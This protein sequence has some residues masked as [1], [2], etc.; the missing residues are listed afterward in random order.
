MT[1]WIELT[2]RL[3]SRPPEDG[4]VTL[5]LVPPVKHGSALLRMNLSRV[6]MEALGWKPK[7]QLTIAFSK[8]GA[9]LRIT[10]A[11]K[12]VE[13]Y[14]LGIR[15]T[16]GTL[17]FRL[18]WLVGEREARPSEQ[19]PH[20]THTA[21]GA[22]IVNLPAWALAKTVS[23]TPLLVKNKKDAPPPAPKPASQVAALPPVAPMPPLPPMKPLT[24]AEAEDLLVQEGKDLLRGG[25][26]VRDV[27]LRLNEELGIVQAWKRQV[28]AE[29][30]KAAA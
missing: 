30:E 18:P 29:K 10:A 19:T 24:A 26:S 9:R 4:R 25:M 7:G 20:V 23:A 17:N 16:T 14:T 28:D 2:P 27:A 22:L 21:E 11:G 3:L 15:G 8:D 12:G 13:G 6:I 1:E 5:A